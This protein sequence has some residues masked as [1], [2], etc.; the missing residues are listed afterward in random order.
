MA[1]I[2]WNAEL[3]TGIREIDRQHRRIIDYLNQ[4]DELRGGDRQ[5]IGHVIEETV[6]YTVSHFVFE[7][8]LMEKA[9]YFFT[10]PHRKIHDIFIRRINGLKERFNAG[11]DVAENL[12]DLLSRWLI[13]HIRA[14]DR[15]YVEA[16][17]AYLQS[18]Q[19]AQASHGKSARELD[20]QMLYNDELQGRKKNWL[21]RLFGR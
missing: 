12:R 7:E 6:D 19:P 8:G 20:A 15:N 5:K 17:N 14:E 21:K 10:D 1:K 16:V 9:G 18:V 4:I 2:I 11:D 3:D 13:N